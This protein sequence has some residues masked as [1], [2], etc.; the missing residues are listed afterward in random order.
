MHD[1]TCAFTSIPDFPY[2]LFCTPYNESY[3]LMEFVLCLYTLTH[4]HHGRNYP[5]CIMT[6]FAEKNIQ[7]KLYYTIQE[8]QLS[9]KISAKV[10]IT[11]VDV[12]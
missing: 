10:S 5:E 4:T 9:S 11:L 2:R 12:M 3:Y 8:H 6:I 7:Y 1:H